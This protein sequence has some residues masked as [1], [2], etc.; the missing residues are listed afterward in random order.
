MTLTQ[1]VIII[2]IVVL[3]TMLTRF[4]PFL[5][6]SSDKPIPPYIHYLGIV[7]LP[8]VFWL[9]V[10]Y[11]V[12]DVNVLSG[13]HGLPEFLALVFIIIL[14][15]WRR[16]MLISIAGGTVFYMFLVQVVF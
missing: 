11:S 13:D 16:S 8:A 1:Q 12:R 10:V 5:I 14:H 4:L 9:L 2:G 15:Y 6:F 3:G 7:L